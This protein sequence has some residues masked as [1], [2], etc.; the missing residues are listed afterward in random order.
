MNSRI[1]LLLSVVMALGLGSSA[2]AATEDSKPE[3]TVCGDGNQRLDGDWNTDFTALYGTP[4]AGCSTCHDGIPALNPY[5]DDADNASGANRTAKLQA[6]EG[7]DSDGD[8]VSN[9]DEINAETNPGDPGDAPAV[10]THLG[11]AACA[12]CH[13]V[14][15]V[16][17]QYT[18]WQTTL[19]SMIYRD[20]SPSTILPTWAGVVSVEDTAAGLGPIWVQLTQAGP[21][22]PAQDFVATIYSDAGLTQMVAGPMTVVRVNGAAHIAENA[23]DDDFLSRG[24]AEDDNPILPGT[25]QYY[26]GESPYL[27]PQLYQVAIG[28]QHYV[29]PIQFNPIPDLDGENGGWVAYELGDWIDA[30]D[31]LVL[32][33]LDSDEFNCAGCHM[34][35]IEEVSFNA[36]AS[37]FVPGTAHEITGAYDLVSSGVIDEFVGCEACHG[38]ASEHPSLAFTPGLASGERGVIRPDLLTV[39]QR[40]DM[41]GAC[42]SRGTSQGMVNSQTLPYPYRDAAPHRPIP[43]DVWGDFFVDG[44]EWWIDETGLRV[45]AA[46]NQQYQEFIETNHFNF[47]FHRLTCGD[48]HDSHGTDN[49]HDLITD[50]EGDPVDGARGLGSANPNNLC[51]SCHAGHGPFDNALADINFERH[52][53]H[54]PLG[55]HGNPDCTNCH[56]PATVTSAVEYDIHSHS[57]HV[58]LPEVTINDQDPN[59]CMIMCHTGS[60]HTSW[61]S[62]NSSSGPVN[63][64]I[65]DWTEPV[66]V[67]ISEWLRAVTPSSAAVTFHLIGSPEYVAVGASDPDW[68]AALDHNADTEATTGT[69]ASPFVIDAADIVT[70]VEAGR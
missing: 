55:T 19:H 65:T 58:L 45:A 54:D 13:S 57:F 42:H 38:P 28:D 12:G 23:N 62:V 20:P 44:G 52:T 11:S 46:D 29:L 26:P 41:C 24:I 69:D 1:A 25:P 59:S 18:T 3:G 35:G 47:Q 14:A 67:T 61:D 33:A 9:I 70:F 17:D 36:A 32:E 68:V 39:D 64:D 50:N 37:A 31:N 53:W 60:R 10:A 8:G 66:D 4:P 16:R 27:G 15:G 21:A 49:E 30:G 51:I 43:G 6:I 48:C 2:W 34:T 7:D 56:M 40:V 5:G 63:T 22:S